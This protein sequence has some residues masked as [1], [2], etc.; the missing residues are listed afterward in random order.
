MNLAL[1]ESLFES[2]KIEKVIKMV[3]NG[4]KHFPAH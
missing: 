2:I 4:E 1:G 3:E